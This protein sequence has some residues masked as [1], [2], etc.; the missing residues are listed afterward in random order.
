M[1]GMTKTKSAFALMRE[2]VF[3]G[4]LF[5]S[6]DLKMAGR[7]FAKEGREAAIEYLRGKD[8]E[9]PANFKP[10]AKGDIIAQS[11]PFDQWPIVQVSQAIQKYI[12]GL[13]KAEFD[14][15]KTLLYGEGN[16]P[17]TESRRRWFEA[18]GVPDFGFTSAQGL[19]AIFSSALARYEG[20]IQ[21]VENRNEK[22]LK[23][24]SEKNQ[25]LV[26]EGHAVEAYVPETAFHTLESL[27]ALSEKSLV[28]LDDLMDKIDRLAQP[29]G[30]N[31][32]LYGYQQVAPYIYDPENPRG[33]V[34]P[35]LYLGYCRKPD[36]PITACPNRLDI[37]KGQP[38]YIPEHQRGQLKKHGRVRRFRY[39]NPQAKARAK[40]Q[41]AILA[42]LRIDEDWVVMD[43][44]GLLRNVYFREV[45]A[46]GELTARTLLDTF[47]GCPVLNLRSNVVTFCYDIESKGALHAEYVRKGWATRNK[48][49][50]LTKDGQSVAL[51]SVDLGQR[52][53]VAVMISR[54]KRD[55]KGDLSE[56]SIQ[57]VSRTFADQYVDKLKRYRVQYDALRKEIYD[58]ALVSLPP[59]QQAEIRAYE[60]FAP[61]D[62]KA[63]V[64]SVMFQGEVSPDELPWDKMNTNTHYISDLY[65]R[66]GGDPSRVFFVPQPSTPKKNAKKP[67]GPRKPVKRTDENVSHMPEFRPHLSNETREAFQKA[68]WT[69]ER[70]NVRYAQLSRFL[71][72]IVREANNWLVS[73]AKKLTQCQTVVWAIEDLHVP[74]FHGKGK[75]HETWDGFFRQ[76][77]EDRWF[78]NVFHKAISERAPNKGE[79]VMEVAPYRTS[80][81]CPV[82]GF[83][84]ADNRH[85]DHFKCLRC[86]VELHA[87]LEVATWNIALVA[88]QGH[89]IA[90]PPREQSCGGETA[91]TARKGKNIKKNKGLADAVTVEAQDSEGGSKKDAG[92]ARNPV[93]IPSESQVNCPAP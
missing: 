75:Y 78:V 9:R 44:R 52:H 5:K 43:L 8:E 38:G 88:V 71:N 24:L 1:L 84:D 32:C 4:L 93:Y 59:E 26:E 66:R 27:K 51:L 80:Q 82:C 87:D 74:F 23:K 40:A 83:V 77:K 46:P 10:P 39:T 41:T 86:G 45:A 58:A 91:G 37:P 15:T 72:Q 73:E 3:P 61:G 67:P 54:L 7:K 14:A 30:I 56:K 76:K 65:L 64:L 16:H 17:T 92:T 47:T 89:G 49:L 85:G 69:M 50:D 21:K 31:P 90:G 6:A 48:L 57:V 29:P 62:A 36:D 25:R 28:P 68:K 33:V 18:T 79:Y 13:T 12:F 34:L 20:V 70:G 60:A 35:D 53:P 63:N 19:N 22:R 11:R 55:D 2:E 42:V 81:R